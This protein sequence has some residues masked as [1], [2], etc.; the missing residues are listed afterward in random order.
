MLIVRL[1]MPS[2]EDLPTKR[3]NPASSEVVAVLLPHK[4]VDERTVVVLLWFEHHCADYG[5]NC[6]KFVHSWCPTCERSKFP[7]THISL[8]EFDK[9]EQRVHQLGDPG[10]ILMFEE[11][12]R[13]ESKSAIHRWKRKNA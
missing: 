6:G 13:E 9:L 11:Q 10:D 8:Q 2:L 7:R 5:Y 12:L 4:L 3:R 1:L